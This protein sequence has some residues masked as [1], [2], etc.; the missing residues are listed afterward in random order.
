MVNV[1]NANTYFMYFIESLYKPEEER[2][3]SDVCG[4]CCEEPK[5][6]YRLQSCFHRFCVV[7]MQTYI[8][9][10]LG[11][12]SQFP[13]KC[14]HCSQLIIVEDLNLILDKTQ[15]QRIETMALNQYIAENSDKMTFCYTAGCR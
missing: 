1:Q 4:I 2:V 9:N 14:P 6:S 3:H 15:W 7:C 10:I 5:A 13:I 11:D 8:R 12:R